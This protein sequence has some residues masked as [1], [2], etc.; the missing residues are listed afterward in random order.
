VPPTPAI[1]LLERT[2]TR[3]WLHE[4]HHDPRTRSFGNEAAVALEVDAPR[5]FKTLV[6]RADDALAVAVVPVSAELDTKAFARS[7]GAKRATIAQPAAVERSTGY[8]LGGVSPLGQKRQLAT[9]IDSSATTFATIFVSGGRR[10]LEV[11]LAAL[12]LAALL[13]GAF[14]DIAAPHNH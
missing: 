13:Q 8:V 12:D 1:D 2:H 7:L 6:V 4:Y 5:V 10:G 11:E 3:Y 9:V 14:A